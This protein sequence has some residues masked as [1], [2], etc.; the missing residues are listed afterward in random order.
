MTL[1]VTLNMNRFQ[2]ARDN[3]LANRLLRQA[4]GIANVARTVFFSGEPSAQ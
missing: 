2:W 4:I 3:T 1:T